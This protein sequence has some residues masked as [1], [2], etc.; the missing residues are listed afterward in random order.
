[1]RSSSHSPV[2]AYAPAFLGLLANRVVERIVE[3]GARYAAQADVRTP[4]RA[5][6]TMLA[7]RAGPATVTELAQMLGV[8]HATAIK[9]TRTLAELGLV[10]RGV[11]KK[12]ARRRPLSLTPQGE[13]A[14]READRFMRRART[15]Y[16][17]IFAEIGADAYA[18]LAAMEAALD[19]KGFDVRLR[20]AGESD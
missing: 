12:D 18:A 16:R 15:A 20:E 7:L 10:T 6:S 3:E 17:E 13:D 8:S 2:G 1:M 11:D 9:N 5:M 4:V 14:A 19:R